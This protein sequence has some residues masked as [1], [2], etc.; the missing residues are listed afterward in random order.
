MTF[1]LCYAASAATKE[2]CLFSLHP[3][4]VLA[5]SCTT[6]ER[7]FMKYLASFGARL[8][9]IFIFFLHLSQFL[10][11]TFNHFDGLIMCVPPL[12][13]CRI[14]FTS[15]LN[16]ALESSTW[17]KKTG[18]RKNVKNENENCSLGI[19]F[20]FPHWALALLKSNESFSCSGW[21]KRNIENYDYWRRQN[22]FY[23]TMRVHATTNLFI[24]KSPCSWLLNDLMKSCQVLIF[25]IFSFGI[26]FFPLSS[27]IHSFACPL[28]LPKQ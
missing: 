13:S 14:T 18:R 5:T 4:S 19:S 7:Y 11:L 21:V 20:F 26:S 2:L 9:W 12:C 8:R 16:V 6:V 22:F 28:L 17:K 1:S 3:T 25:Q 23:Y 15:T 10:L 24:M 27:S